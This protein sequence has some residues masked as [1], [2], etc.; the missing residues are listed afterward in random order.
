MS[1]TKYIYTV[2]SFVFIIINIHIFVDIMKK[3]MCDR[4]KKTRADSAQNVH[5]WKLTFICDLK[6][7][8]KGK[9]L[10]SSVIK[11]IID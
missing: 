4:D 7:K 6:K 10:L 1:M 8:K 9:H 11:I 5:Q 3:N 2:P